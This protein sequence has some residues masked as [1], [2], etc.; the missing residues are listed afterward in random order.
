MTTVTARRKMKRWITTSR[1]T[2]ERTASGRTT[3]SRPDD[4]CPGEES[5]SSPPKHPT[6]RPGR[7]S[8][9]STPNGGGTSEKSDRCSCEECERKQRI[10]EKSTTDP[11][12]RESTT[13]KELSS[14][15][16]TPSWKT[17]DSS[18]TEQRGTA[19]PG[20]RNRTGK[21]SGTTEHFPCTCKSCT[22]NKD[23]DDDND[24]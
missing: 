6:D 22:V 9:K 7:C 23:D 21:R 10:D 2:T 8:N 11:R 13:R 5:R 16:T 12:D 24:R 20:P 17:V 18:A 4:P 1:T 3:T 19:A 15:G 14:A